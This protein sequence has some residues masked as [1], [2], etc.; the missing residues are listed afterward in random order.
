MI[1]LFTLD[2]HSFTEL[3]E[4][5]INSTKNEGTFVSTTAF[6]TAMDY[7]F[8]HGCVVIIGHSGAGKSRLG[9]E[10]LHQYTQQHKEYTNSAI[11]SS[12]ADFQENLEIDEHC[13]ILLD[14]I[15]GQTISQ[16]NEKNNSEYVKALSSY[17]NGK[18]VKVV[19]TMRGSVKRMCISLK[20]MRLFKNIVDLGS[21]KFKM[22]RTN[23]KQCLENYLK[24]NQIQIVDDHKRSGGHLPEQQSLSS[25]S[26][27]EIVDIDE[28]PILGFPQVCYLFTSHKT[29]LY[30]GVDFFRHANEVLLRKIKKIKEQVDRGNI[31]FTVLAY[32]LFNGDKLDLNNLNL[33]QLIRSTFRSVFHV[34]MLLDK[35]DIHISVEFLK[36]YLLKEEIGKTLCFQHRSIFEA[37]FLVVSECKMNMNEIIKLMDFD[38]IIEMTRSGDYEKLEGDVSFVIPSVHYK[39]LADRIVFHLRYCKDKEPFSFFKRLCESPILQQSGSEVIKK[40]LQHEE[41]I[42]NVFPERKYSLKCPERKDQSVVTSWCPFVMAIAFIIYC[43]DGTLLYLESYIRDKLASN[44]SLRKQY[45]DASM[46][47]FLI[48]C[49]ICNSEKA[50]TIWNILKTEKRN[51]NISD[52]VLVH[53]HEILK[54]E[55]SLRIFLD[56]VDNHTVLNP[57]IFLKCLYFRD[58]NIKNVETIIN[59]YGQFVIDMDLA[60]NLACCNGNVELVKSFLFQHKNINFD[61]ISAMNKACGHGNWDLISFL[62]DTVE[63]YKFDM[64][65]AMNEACWNGKVEIVESLFNKLGI[66]AFDMQSAMNNACGNTMDNVEVVKF[67][68]NNCDGQEGIYLKQ[69]MDWA[70]KR[71]QYEFIKYLLREYTCESFDMKIILI[72][73]CENGRT[74]FVQYLLNKDKFSQDCYDLQSAINQ[75][76]DY[77]HV[78]LVCLILES[79]D[80]RE[81]SMKLVMQRACES[82]WDTLCI[83]DFLL[84]KFDHDLFDIEQVILWACKIGHEH[85]VKNFIDRYRSSKFDQKSAMKTACGS[86][87]RCTKVIEC[88]LKEFDNSSLDIA[89]ALESACKTVNFD[90]VELLLKNKIIDSTGV[91]L[92]LKVKSNKDI[93]EILQKKLTLLE[94]PQCCTLC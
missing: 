79:I 38:F 81:I 70:L 4:A 21:K 31:H 40:M 58:V 52:Q 41:E 10:L 88:L 17:V 54:N 34:D 90:V 15:F 35:N 73:A 71:C 76:F 56:T 78:Q 86:F 49:R 83:V 20:K 45:E 94:S 13:I 66:K 57:N 68:I 64:K 43:N 16:Y 63:N 19:I 59:K 37:V 72:S 74:D 93:K 29:F 36:G 1:S 26:I 80:H 51:D 89:S 65:S 25:Q 22:T 30:Q 24:F 42:I 92:A 55:K 91:R 53:M 84:E 47:S 44:N 12:L 85:L 61:M 23:K 48:F 87:W 18:K 39:S 60:M 69:I 82:N 32:T 9:L 5:D 6:S 3:C 14:D 77:Q 11:K 67:L 2:Y 62:L 28:S 7:I 33:V 8:K 27:D 50:K 75:A 46:I